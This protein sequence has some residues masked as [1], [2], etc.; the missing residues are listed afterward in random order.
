MKRY[1][2]HLKVQVMAFYLICFTHISGEYFLEGF[3]LE[4][5]GVKVVFQAATA[6]LW[7]YCISG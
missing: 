7:R 6:G 5:Y 1:I 3:L 2:L 4:K